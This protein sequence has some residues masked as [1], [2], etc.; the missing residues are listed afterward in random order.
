MSWDKP[1]TISRIR[2]FFDTDF[3]IILD[4]CVVAPAE[5]ERIYMPWLE[6]R[7]LSF[8]ALV[9]KLP[10]YRFRASFVGRL[11]DFVVEARS[12]APQAAGDVRFAYRAD[13]SAYRYDGFLDLYRADYGFWTSAPFLGAGNFRGRFSGA[14]ADSLSS[15]RL[16]AMAGH[17]NLFDSHVRGLHFW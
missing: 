5:L 3:D 1:Q 4:E 7:Y 15:F 12:L 2:L 17:V 13:S 8:P 9:H 6:S 10:V 14:Y 11:E 16:G